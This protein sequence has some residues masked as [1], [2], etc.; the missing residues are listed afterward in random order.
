MITLATWSVA[1]TTITEM[2]F[3]RIWRKMIR[4]WLIPRARPAVMKSR[5][6]MAMVSARMTR[7]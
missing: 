6:R 1:I 5:S 3:G 4:R 7:A 2:R